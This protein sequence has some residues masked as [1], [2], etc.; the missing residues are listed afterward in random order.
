M[1]NKIL[2]YIGFVLFSML[3]SKVHA[4]S[5]HFNELI[6]TGM[7]KDILITVSGYGRTNDGLLDE[8]KIDI[9]NTSETKVYELLIDDRIVRQYWIMITGEGRPLNNPLEGFDQ[10]D[11]DGVSFNL[12]T[13]GPNQTVPFI[14][15][16]ESA[17]NVKSDAY[18]NFEI[19]DL[20]LYI[21]LPVYA[22]GSDTDQDARIGMIQV[23]SLLKAVPVFA[24]SD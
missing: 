5:Q 9:T 15:K 3:I 4:D 20:N 23:R 18:S 12:I 13:I 19:V 6:A 2:N 8:V 24:G 10:P 11:L 14:M 1:F 17:A 16:I 22:E 7:D 21:D